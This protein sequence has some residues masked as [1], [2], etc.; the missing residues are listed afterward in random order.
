[1]EIASIFHKPSAIATL[2]N[3]NG[4]ADLELLLYT[5]E[6]WNSQPPTVYLFC[7][8]EVQEWLPGKYK[9]TICAN[10]VLDAYENLT[11]REMEGMPSRS[12]L[13]GRTN[14]FFDFM[15]EKC[16][17]MKWAFEKMPVA[18][19]ANGLLFCDAD[20]FWLGP[21]P[22]IDMSKQVMLSPHEIHPSD[23]A[24]YGKYNGGFFWMREPSA[25]DH[26][27]NACETARFFEQSAL[28]SL[29]DGTFSFGEFSKQVNYGWWRMFQS[30]KGAKAQQGAWS[31]KRDS[32]QKH[33]G[34]QV[35]GQPLVCIHTHWKTDDRITHM[36]NE[37]VES[38]LSLLK[39]QTKVRA[40]LKK[41]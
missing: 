26:W 10:P 9:G 39:T 37:W 13:K 33:S 2:A 7:T 18:E 16:H 38:K 6:L 35:E 15:E 32:E 12:G 1:M 25:V 28:E 5:L 24:K 41:I 40:L 31:I 17:L 14:L 11:R 29:A 36:F 34:I 23:E 27:Q 22:L 20:I 19:K 21:L 4:I 30:P 3:S 8:T